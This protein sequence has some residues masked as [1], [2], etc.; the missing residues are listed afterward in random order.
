[1]SQHLLENDLGNLIGLLTR[2]LVSQPPLKSNWSRLASDGASSHPL[3]DYLYKHNCIQLQDKT[4]FALLSTTSSIPTMAPQP[5]GSGDSDESHRLIDPEHFARDDEESFASLGEK[6]LPSSWISNDSI[7]RPLILNNI[8][9]NPKTYLISTILFLLPSF[10]VEPVRE[11]SASSRPS[12]RRSQLSSTA[13]LDGLRG[14][15]ALTVYIFH[16][17]MLWFDKVIMDA[18]GAP[19][20]A[21]TFAQLPIIR[22]FNSGT[23]SVA[24]FFMISGYVITIKTLTLIHKGGPQ[25]NE[26]ILSTLCGALFR[27]PLRLFV[28]AIVSTFMIAVLNSQFGIFTGA[29]HRLPDLK[30]QLI[31]WFNETLKMLNTFNL[32]KTRYGV[33]VPRY[34]AH[35][36]TIPIEFKNS[37]LLFTLLLAFSK[38]K[39]WIHVMGVLGVAWCLIFTQGDIDAGLFCAGLIL[40]EMTLIFPPDGQRSQAKA[41]SGSDISLEDHHGNTYLSQS[42]GVR[43]WTRHFITIS[44]AILGLHLM[45][46]PLQDNVH[47]GGFKTISEWTPRPF[48]PEPGSVPYGQAVWSIAIGA[49]LYITACTY[50]A[51]LRLPPHLS[52]WIPTGVPWS[53][54]KREESDGTAVLSASVPIDQP[55]FLQIPHTTRFAQYLGWVSYSLYLCHGSVIVST[56]MFKYAEASVAWEEGQ[57]LARQFQ[58]SGQLVAAVE[59]VGAAWDAYVWAFLRASVP[60]TILLFWVSDV[61]A[62]SLD[63]NIV[64]MTR[65]LWNA[66]KV[67]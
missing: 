41:N 12:T 57:E 48:Y 24:T 22:T 23:A 51:P 40:A 35:L 9:R 46:Y 36:W 56:G 66:A 60:Q 19:G 61:F 65:W 47:A 45:G 7:R 59:T 55:P 4:N 16:W 15:A 18:Y 63:V 25:N 67:E 58:A 10:I 2:I 30:S 29:V 28:P 39:R 52:K 42:V 53:Q 38:V 49:V 44:S 14:I 3:V 50:S 13:W 11:Y 8:L 6:S 33:A 20:S 17:S 37:V 62:R 43:Y 31:D 21:N 32:H 27:R 5:S 1:M 26:R 64:K 54:S 34:N